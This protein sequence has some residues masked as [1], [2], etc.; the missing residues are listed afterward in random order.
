MAALGDRVQR[1][2]LSLPFTSVLLTMASRTA[3]SQGPLLPEVSA[4]HWRELFSLSW[5]P[6]DTDEENK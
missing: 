4:P 1:K 6:G 5:R 3:V 2:T